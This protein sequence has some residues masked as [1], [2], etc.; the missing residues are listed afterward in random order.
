MQM[1]LKE[2]HGKSHGKHIT[3][4]ESKHSFRSQKQIANCANIHS[5]CAI[6]PKQKHDPN[7]YFH[8]EISVGQTVIHFYESLKYWCPGFQRLQFT[9]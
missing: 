8:S 4:S 6:L 2:T 7:L 3:I 9:P 5:W 1:L